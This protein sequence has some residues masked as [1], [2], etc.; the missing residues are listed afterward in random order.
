MLMCGKL[1]ET[2]KGEQFRV[3]DQLIFSK[4]DSPKRLLIMIQGLIGG[5]DLGRAGGRA[6]ATK[7]HLQGEKRL[8][9]CPDCGVGS[10][11]EFWEPA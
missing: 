4:L 7:S 10:D 2:S 11:P 1:G 3:L 8:K 9:R 6:R 5:A